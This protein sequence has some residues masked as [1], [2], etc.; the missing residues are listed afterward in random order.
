MQFVW[1]CVMAIPRVNFAG[2]RSEISHCAFSLALNHK[3]LSGEETTKIMLSMWMAKIMVL[4]G[5]W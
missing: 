3:F 1:S 5:D 2:P 4:E